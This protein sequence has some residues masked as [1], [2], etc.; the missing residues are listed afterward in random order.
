MVLGLGM[1]TTEQQNIV[2][3]ESSDIQ[4]G[5]EWNNMMDK[6]V[7]QHVKKAEQE[8]RKILNENLHQLESISRILL[9]KR[10]IVDAEL[11]D[12]LLKK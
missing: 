7:E 3:V 11:T 10:T 9:E 12:L 1:S 4:H 5:P 2:Q 8:C 6:S